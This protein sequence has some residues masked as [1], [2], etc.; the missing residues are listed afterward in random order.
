M[1]GQDSKQSMLYQ[2]GSRANRIAKQE[3]V[4]QV[5]TNVIYGLKCG[6][7]LAKLDRS[8]L[9]LKM[10]GDYCQ[11]KM[12]GS[13]EEYSGTFPTWGLMLDGAVYE[14][15]ISEQSTEEKEWELLPTVAA[16]AAWYGNLKKVEWNGE[17]KHSMTLIQALKR[18][19]DDATNLNPNF[20]EILMG[21]PIGW[22]ELSPLETQ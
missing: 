5:L 14:L 11:V 18:G 19:G 12:D 4:K 16:C 9:W 3:N 22:T 6:E 10:Y 8:G 21:F 15:P 2:G 13:L 17:N 1:K 7:L 20:C